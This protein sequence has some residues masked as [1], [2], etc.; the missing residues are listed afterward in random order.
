MRTD[1]SSVR[2]AA[3]T[4]RGLLRALPVGAAGAVGLGALAA[5]EPDAPESAPRGAEAPAVPV[6]P[7]P[8]LLG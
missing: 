6:D 3:V 1:T 2:P 4:R 8:A 7:A 5:C